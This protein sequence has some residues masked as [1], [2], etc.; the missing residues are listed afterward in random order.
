MPAHTDRVFNHATHGFKQLQAAPTNFT[1]SLVNLFLEL[2]PGSNMH[3]LKIKAYNE[4]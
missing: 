4:T 1:V 3:L 2:A